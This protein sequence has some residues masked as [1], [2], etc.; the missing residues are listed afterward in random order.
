MTEHP[1]TRFASSWRHI[2][3][4]CGGAKTLHRSLAV[5]AC[6]ALCP[7]HGLEFHV[8]GLVAV[9]RANA[10]GCGD[11]KAH[12]CFMNELLD[13][14][15]CRAACVRCGSRSRSSRHRTWYGSHGH[16]PAMVMRFAACRACID[17][18]L[19]LASAET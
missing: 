18:E 11:P 9:A 16:G 1:P 3:H 5:F 4:I 12:D 6:P 8:R 19:V 14:S 2:C 15:G 13:V 17:A 7:R 10:C